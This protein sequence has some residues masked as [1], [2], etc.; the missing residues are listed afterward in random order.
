MNVL[1]EIPQSYSHQGNLELDQTKYTIETWD[2][3]SMDLEM[4]KLLSK[5]CA[6]CE[7]DMQSWIILLCLFTSEQVLLDMWSYRMWQ[8]Q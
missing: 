6:F 1:D 8:E 3:E 5:V 7:K 4:V 2:H